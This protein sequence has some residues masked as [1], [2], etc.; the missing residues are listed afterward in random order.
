M[1]SAQVLELHHAANFGLE[2]MAC[3]IEQVVERGVVGGFL[4][5][6]AGAV[7]TLCGA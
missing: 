6:A 1:A 4:G 2:R 5:A 3:A 7:N